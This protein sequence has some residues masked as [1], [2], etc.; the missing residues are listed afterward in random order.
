[1]SRTIAVVGTLDT[2]GKE[3]NYINKRIKEY[4]FNKQIKTIVIDSGILGAPEGIVPDITR[5]QVAKAT[6][7]SIEDVRGA[8]SRGESVRLMAEGL[9]N[10]L[11][12]LFEKNML[13]GAVTLA[14]VTGGEL[15]TPAFESLPIGIPKM[16]ATP[17]AS[18]VRPFSLFIRSKDIMVMHTVVDILGINPISKVIFDNLAGAMVGACL[19]SRESIKAQKLVAM[20][21]QGN[22][23][24]GGMYVKSKIEEKG[25]KTVV[26]H[27]NGVG[28]RSMEKLAQEGWFC[29]VVD[30]TT[31]EVY[32]DIIGGLQKGAG[33]ERLTVI[34]ELGIPQ[35]V[36]TGAI[37]SFDQGPI[38]EIPERWQKRKLYSHSPSI[39]LVR[40]TEEEM[41][42]LGT[43]FARRLNLSQGPVKVVIPLLGTSIPNYV[44]GEF[45]DVKADKAFVRKLREDLRE[46]I[47]IVEIDAHINDEKFAMEVTRILL[48]I[49]E[50]V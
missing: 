24:R 5:E 29:G 30:F 49:M 38:D 4:G 28:G 22:T 17:L 14:G 46:D 19:T 48:E 31:N 2:K 1:M 15:V 44:G 9:K 34:G 41:G 21:L 33:P 3:I 6:G 39:T 8:G 20:T 16:I 26:F 12:G 10:L 35:V 45:W 13:H 25:Y 32:E 11:F 37:D 23:T 47:D 40:L 7:L 50:N 27:S 43:V 18:G 42:Y 36:V